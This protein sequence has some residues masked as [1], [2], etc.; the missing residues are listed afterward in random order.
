[1]GRTVTDNCDVVTK[2]DNPSQLYCHQAFPFVPN[3]KLL[4]AY[5]FPAHVE[6]A[7]TLQSIPGN[8]EQANFVA[9]NAQNFQ[10]L[11]SNLSTGANGTV[12]VNLVQPGSLLSARVNQLDVRLSRGFK[13]GQ[14]SMKG[15]FD[16]YNLFNANPVIAWNNTYGTNGASWLQPLQIL[17]GRLIKL[18]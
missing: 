8:P 9:T 6:V 10:S 5:T 4:G 17:T 1:V 13:L 7:A 12:S 11:G 3:V 16:I 2:V 14:T 15:M 18:S